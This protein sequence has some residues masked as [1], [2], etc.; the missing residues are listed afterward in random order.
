[1]AGVIVHLNNSGGYHDRDVEIPNFYV[2]PE[3][4]Q[5]AG[6]IYMRSTPDDERNATYRE[7]T[8][9]QAHDPSGQQK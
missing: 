6:R 7:I 5:Y 9:V 4:V 3:F 1:M 2:P 8:F